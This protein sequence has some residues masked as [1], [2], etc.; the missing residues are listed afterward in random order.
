MQNSS[1]QPAQHTVW[2]PNISGAV[3]RHTLIRLELRSRGPESAIFP[4]YEC[5]QS[6]VERDY[7]CIRPNIPRQELRQMYGPL[8]V[9]KGW[10]GA[11]QAW[12]PVWEPEGSR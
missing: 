1:P 3:T 4:V 11:E 6:G 2:L 8:V 7:G 9:D 12:V 5:D 10:P